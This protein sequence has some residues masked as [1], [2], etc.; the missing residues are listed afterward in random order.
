[1]RFDSTTHY[2]CSCLIHPQNW[3]DHSSRSFDIAQLPDYVSARSQTEAV[4]HGC[5]ETCGCSGAD[6]R[7]C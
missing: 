3:S 1:M 6:G 5:A 2:E 7:M 4:Q